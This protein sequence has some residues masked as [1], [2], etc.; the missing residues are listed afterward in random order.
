VRRNA[1]FSPIGGG[2]GVKAFTT[3]DLHAAYN[4]GDTGVLSNTEISL[5]ALNVLNKE[6][7]FFNAAIGYDLFNANPIGRLVTLGLSKK[8]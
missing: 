5:T 4:F 1:A 3:I 7:P 2:Q 8:W 6:P